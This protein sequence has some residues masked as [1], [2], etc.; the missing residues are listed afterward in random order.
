M[1]LI[2][3]IKA[4]F[5]GGVLHPVW[6]PAYCCELLGQMIGE[7]PALMLILASVCVHVMGAK[8]EVRGCRKKFQK[9]N[10]SNKLGDVI[11][12]VV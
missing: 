4:A 6:L 8:R 10:G 9:K 1:E 7:E 3:L 2:P 5:H 12:K 11:Q